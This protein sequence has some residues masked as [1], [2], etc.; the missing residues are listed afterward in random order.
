M[1]LSRARHLE[2]SV[3]RNDD[4][5]AQQ[6]L[7]FLTQP[8]EQ[9]IPAR[10]RTVQNHGK[11]YLQ[12]I[13]WKESLLAVRV[14]LDC[15][16]VAE[17]ISRLQEKLPPQ[18]DTIRAYLYERVAG[19]LRDLQG[20]RHTSVIVIQEAELLVRYHVPLVFLYELTGDAHAIILHL[21]PGPHLRKWKFPS[22]V[23]YNP[24]AAAAYF[25][26][27]L[28]GQFIREDQAEE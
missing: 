19:R 14:S 22:Y 1:I 2:K 25:V 5:N 16:T 26:Q 23:H 28:G 6:L 3:P 11:R 27:A 18:E 21:E 13:L 7:P 10:V 24:E 17:L 9:A 20:G 12:D 4:Q 8:S 15:Q